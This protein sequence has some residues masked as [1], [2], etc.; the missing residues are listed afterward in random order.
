MTALFSEVPIGASF[1]F[2]GL[3][4]CKVALSMAQ[5]E[6]EWGS[7]FQGE[8]LVRVAEG[9]PLF[10]G[11]KQPEPYWADHLSPAPGQR[12]R[13]PRTGLA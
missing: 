3:R 13:P 8:T 6:R 1:E 10:Q 5:D 9:Q 4:Y 2:R 11:P 12:V 7:I